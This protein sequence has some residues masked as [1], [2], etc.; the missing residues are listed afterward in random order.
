MMTYEEVK[1]LLDKLT[2]FGVEFELTIKS[3]GCDRL[4]VSQLRQTN[5]YYH[6]ILSTL[7]SFAGRLDKSISYGTQSWSGEK[8]GLDITVYNVA[9]CK[10]VGYNTVERKK[11]VEV[12]TEEIE[13]TEV[14]IYDC[15]EIES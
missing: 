9:S 11:V 4:W 13:T 6:H 5:E 15:R 2:E 7:T 10:I 1:P 3:K 12:E 14:P 8:D